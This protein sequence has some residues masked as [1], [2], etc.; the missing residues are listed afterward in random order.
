MVVSNQSKLRY[1][2]AQLNGENLVVLQRVLEPEVMDTPEEALDYDSMDHSQVNQL[3]VDDLIA[4]GE[5]GHDILDLG[6]G[7]AQI[8]I[9]LCQR[10]EDNRVMAVDLA[11]AMLDL[12][13]LNI[14]VESLIQRISLDRVDA[15]DMPYADGAFDLVISNSIIHHIPEP[16]KVF[17]ESVRVLKKDGGRLFFRDLMRP[18]TNERV[19][20]L[21]ELY[22]GEENEHQQKM[23]DDSL[24]AALSLTEVRELVGWLG[25]DSESVQATSDRHWT[26][27][28]VLNETDTSD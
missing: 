12:A 16:K 4:G 27:Q 6:T 5:V 26:W 8:P 3:F 20:E 28:V 14:E 10:T 11:I 18:E 22:A 2:T 21:V 15:K 25:F 24:R 1:G 9:V 17:E 23:F 13:R 7:T 19:A